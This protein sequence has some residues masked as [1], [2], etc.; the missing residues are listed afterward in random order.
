MTQRGGPPDVVPTLTEVIDWPQAESAP[1]GDPVEEPPLAP[2]PEPVRE[3]PT[4]PLPEGDPPGSP[5]PSRDPPVGPGDE[6]PAPVH[7]QSDE[8][9][10]SSLPAAPPSVLDERQLVERILVELQRQVDG[11]V[12]YRLREVLAPILSRAT[13]AIVRDARSNLSTSLRDLV[14]QSVA[15]ELRRQRTR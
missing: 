2:V 5:A 4:E 3:P 11:V 13:D 8:A 14:A 15:Q 1:N 6:P 10:G 7:A 12:E 9:G